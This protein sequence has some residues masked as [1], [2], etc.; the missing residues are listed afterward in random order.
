MD[1]NLDRILTTG[2]L[3]IA[4][5]QM[6]AARDG[7]HHIMLATVAKSQR[8]T[9]LDLPQM[10]SPW[11]SCSSLWKYKA[12]QPHWKTDCCLLENKACR[13][14]AHY[15]TLPYIYPMELKNP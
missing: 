10:G 8:S 5:G 1:P 7:S 11:S 14:Q 9:C 2:E 13:Y 4:T 15:N 3:Q 12:T 6:E